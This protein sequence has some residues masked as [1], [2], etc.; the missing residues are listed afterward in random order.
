M[1][2]MASSIV[3]ASSQLISQCVSCQ[4]GARDQAAQELSMTILMPKSANQEEKEEKKWKGGGGETFVIRKNRN[5]AI[6]GFDVK[7]GSLSAE[8]GPS[9]LEG[10]GKKLNKRTGKVRRSE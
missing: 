2:W 1:T 8:W 9:N 10:M 5:A 3:M 6:S 4:P 7:R